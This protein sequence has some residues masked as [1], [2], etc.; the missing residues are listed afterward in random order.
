MAQHACKKDQ[1][2]AFCYH[3]TENILNLKHNQAQAQYI[4]VQVGL[5]S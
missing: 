3:I 1:G 2:L 5:V 4:F